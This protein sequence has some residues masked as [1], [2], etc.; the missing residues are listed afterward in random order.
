M[1]F[2]RPDAQ[3][4][5]HRIPYDSHIPLAKWHKISST[6]VPTRLKEMI[7][8]VNVQQNSWY[9]SGANRM[10]ASAKSVKRKALRASI[11][12]SDVFRG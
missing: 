7:A 12:Y 5:V 2:C 6:I 1:S 3:R 11:L 9:R 10:K 8:D 4:L